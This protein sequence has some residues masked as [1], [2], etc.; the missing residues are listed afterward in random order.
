MNAQSYEYLAKK[1]IQN[2]QVFLQLS[3]FQMTIN[4]QATDVKT[5]I[6][7]FLDCSKYVCVIKLKLLHQAK[8]L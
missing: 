7:Y 6:V 5:F 1:A 3:A 8:S 4:A 2:L